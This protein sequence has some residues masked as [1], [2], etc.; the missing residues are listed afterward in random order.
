[1]AGSAVIME[2]WRRE[3]PAL[4]VLWY[5]GMEGGH[6][7]A[8][9]LFGA[10]A[11]SGRLPFVSPTSEDQLPHFDRDAT[12]ITYDL[13]HGYRKLDRDGA[14]PAF[15][16]GFGLTYTQFTYRSA[17]VDRDEVSA[18]DTIEVSVEVENT[19]ARDADE[20]VQIYAEAIDSA[21]ER[22]PRELRGFA[23]IAVPAGQARVARIPLAVRSLAY[24]DE[25]RDDF[26]VE[27]IAYDLVAA[28]HERDDA[29][30]RVRIRVRP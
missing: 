21:I 15:P 5:P 10:V 28:R 3:V 6:A 4:L 8:D 20:V 22:A 24:F 19:G 12:A 17:S 13:W 29:A 27:P 2:S 16:F 7:L 11:P 9:V 18:D 25:A 26:A 1:M 23:R 14:T 30:P